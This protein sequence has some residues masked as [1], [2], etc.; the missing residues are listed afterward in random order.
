MLMNFNG[1]KL[2]AISITYSGINPNFHEICE[3]GIVPMNYN[4]DRDRRFNPLY[5]TIKSTNFELYDSQTANI[6]KKDFIKIQSTG[7]DSLDAYD[8]IMKYI[9]SLKL[10]KT[11]FGTDRRIIPLVYNYGLFYS[12]M[13]ST[14]GPIAFQDMFHHWYRDLLPVAAAIQDYQVR[15][16]VKEL[17]FP[18]LDLGYISCQLSIPNRSLKGVLPTCVK[19][20][21]CYKK[22]VMEGSLGDPTTHG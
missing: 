13:T 15:K 2:C 16:M 12:L 18:K 20:Q 7:V 22:I 5:L 3:I 8:H 11:K 4:F 21:R 14:F 10:K 1:N 19:I 17:A 9:K 6:S